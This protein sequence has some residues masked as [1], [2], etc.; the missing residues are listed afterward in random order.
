MLRYVM[1]AAVTPLRRRA[2]DVA[3]LLP[4][5]A[6]ARYA[7]RYYRQIIFRHTPSCRLMLPYFFAVSDADYCRHA[8]F[9]VILLDLRHAAATPLR[10]CR[11]CRYA[12]MLI[13]VADAA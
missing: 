6:T 9:D 12:A 10:H 13:S 4:F 7:C 11:Y 5:A 8:A 3:A 2:A 1:S